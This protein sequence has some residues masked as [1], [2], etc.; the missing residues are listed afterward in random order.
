MLSKVPLWYVG[1]FDGGRMKVCSGPVCD[2]CERGVGKQLRYVAC[3]VE[4]TSRQ[5]GVIEFSKPVAELLRDWSRRN[6]GFRGMMVEFTKATKSK[7]SRME[8]KYIDAVATPFCLA[9]EPYDLGEVM[10]LTWE[11]LG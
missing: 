1:H 4:P 8:V 11:R 10:R 3:G 2:C 9:V 6:G 7:H 5:L